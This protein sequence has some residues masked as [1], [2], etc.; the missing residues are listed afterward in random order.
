MS[1]SGAA[2]ILITGN[3][4]LA[5]WG[6]SIFLSNRGYRDVDW[7][8]CDKNLKKIIS[9][10]H[11]D[12]VIMDSNVSGVDG[13]DLI[14]SFSRRK[15]HPEFLVLSDLP[16]KVHAR[17]YRVAGAS[18]FVRKEDDMS[19]V[20]H[21][22]ESIFDGCLCFPESIHMEDDGCTSGIDAMSFL[23]SRELSVFDKLV[24]GMKN[25]EVAASLQMREKYVSACKARVY[26]KLGVSSVA[27]LIEV[28][29]QNGVI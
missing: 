17:R 4:P 26:K 22:L 28:A 19:I 15:V 1:R 11:P 25:K 23:S 14:S 12:I 6:L 8:K 16:D 27:E 5:C 20:A 24:L 10:S 9:F 2:K 29:R 7:V 13:I 21:A 3:H 18:G